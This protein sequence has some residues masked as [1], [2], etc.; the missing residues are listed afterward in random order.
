[1]SVGAA[2]V[3]GAAWV[4]AGRA[5]TDRD[6]L[7]WTRR[8]GALAGVAA[9][10][11]LAVVLALRGGQILDEFRGA[12]GQEVSQSP[13]RLAELSSSNRWRWWQESWTLFKDAPAG[14]KGAATFEIARR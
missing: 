13:T 4:L 3:V 5:L 7:I 10:V 12:G 2:V 1:I 14:G 6:R 9:L 11:A 8:L